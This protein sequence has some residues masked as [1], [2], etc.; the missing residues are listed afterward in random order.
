MCRDYDGGM[1]TSIDQKNFVKT[2]L[3]LPPDLHAAVHEEAQR[4]G[5]SYN[6]ELVERIQGSFDDQA[7]GGAV[8]LLLNL[9]YDLAASQTNS[10]I[11][12]MAI[13]E[14]AEKVISLGE[15]AGQTGKKDLE[16]E[17]ALLKDFSEYLLKNH[18]GDFSKLREAYAEAEKHA[19]E[20]A[21]MFA[22]SEQVEPDAEER[23]SES[24]ARASK[25]VRAKKRA[26]TLPNK[27]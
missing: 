7:D 22:P 6:A 3:R 11:L 15:R 23:A 26:D 18:R 1:A 5:R 4:N 13:T 27:S 19:V 21:Q 12:R 16:N 8:G 20:L 2:A 17:I 25:P 24:V 10:H 9:Q 14:L